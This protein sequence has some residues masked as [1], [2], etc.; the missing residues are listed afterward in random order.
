VYVEQLAPA[1]LAASYA[2]TWPTA[3]PGAQAI[4]QITAAGQH[5]WSNTVPNAATFSAG[6][7]VSASGATITG[8]SSVTGNLNVTG[9]LGSAAY[10]A[11]GLIT[12]NAGL[13]AA[14]NQHVTVSGIGA[15]KHGSRV[16]IISFAAFYLDTSPAGLANDR[17][18]STNLFACVADFGLHA[19]DRITRVD[20]FIKDNATGTTQI[21][22]SVKKLTT[23]TG[24]AATITSAGSVGNGTNQ[25]LSMTGLTETVTAGTAYYVFAT[26]SAANQ[27]FYYSAEVT[28][29]RP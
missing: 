9:T 21:T 1:A 6:V 13:T 22:A 7:T 26:Q 10:T 25:T 19:G 28:Y 17:V 16:K 24:S 11:T 2:M 14:A 15:F 20:V 12:A 18:A 27:V 8:D 3:L 23:T 29:D 5:V 4:A